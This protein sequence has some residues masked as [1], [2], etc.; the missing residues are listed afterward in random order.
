M[1]SPTRSPSGLLALPPMGDRTTAALAV[2]K[3]PGPTS[4]DIVSRLRRSMGTR[5]V[6]HTGTLDPFA[7]GLLIL[8]TGPATRL[9]EYLTGLPKTYVAEARLGIRTDTDDREGRVVA[10][11]EAWKDL[12]REPFEQLMEGFLGPI[13]QVPPP[14]SAKKVDGE[15]AHRRAR[16]GEE[17]ILPPTRVEIMSLEMLEWDLPSIRFRVSCSSG[18]YIRALARDFGERAGVGAHL[19]SLRRV[20]VGRF[21]V[22]TAFPADS[23]ISGST[24]GY[25]WIDPVEVVSHLARFDVDSAQVEALRQG[26][27]IAAPDRGL[28]AGTMA[29]LV[30]ESELVAIGEWREGNLHPR[31]VLG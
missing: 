7:S 31:K 1:R 16:R 28:C 26:R 13:D 3:P 14:F 27:P 24:P 11:S 17:V 6:G 12:G 15:R 29:A 9:S 22:D 8:L 19:T 18:T 5:R 25:G 21:Q 4:H 20:A 10:E 2:D 30:H 23:L